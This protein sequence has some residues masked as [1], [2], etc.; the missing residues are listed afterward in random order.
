MQ[1]GGGRIRDTFPN[2]Y[3]FSRLDKGYTKD[4]TPIAHSDT[5]VLCACFAMTDWQTG[6]IKVENDISR[7]HQTQT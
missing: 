2:G 4:T 3:E 1:S 7:V 5:C 6:H